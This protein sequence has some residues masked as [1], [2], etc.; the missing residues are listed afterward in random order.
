[1]TIKIN[2]KLYCLP[3][4]IVLSPSHSYEEPFSSTELPLK[5]YTLIFFPPEALDLPDMVT[6]SKLQF[7]FIKL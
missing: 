7:I 2:E 5:G 3:C 1:M 4:K 6:I